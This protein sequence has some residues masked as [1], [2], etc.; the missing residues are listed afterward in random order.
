MVC[1]VRME[2]LAGMVGE[3][4]I[5]IKPAKWRQAYKMHDTRFSKKDANNVHR[6]FKPFSF[7]LHAKLIDL[8]SRPVMFEHLKSGL[9]AL[10][11]AFGE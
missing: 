3:A 2:L 9:V 5:A 8:V 11:S 4:D 1:W 6:R 7:C 10:E